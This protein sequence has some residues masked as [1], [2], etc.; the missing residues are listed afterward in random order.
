MSLLDKCVVKL[1]LYRCYSDC[2]KS[3]PDHEIL[4]ENKHTVDNKEK[5]HS[6]SE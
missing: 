2:L 4:K 5:E 6:F 1:Q 3:E